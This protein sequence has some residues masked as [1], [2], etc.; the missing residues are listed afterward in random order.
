MEGGQGEGGLRG[1]NGRG[2]SGLRVGVLD[3]LAGLCVVVALLLREEEGGRWRGCQDLE[4]ESRGWRGEELSELSVVLWVLEVVL[5]V[6][7]SC[8]EL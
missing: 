8:C 3:G 5:I 2:V 4:R 1:W 6:L 7:C